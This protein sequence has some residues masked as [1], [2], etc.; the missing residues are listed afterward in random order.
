[1]T[2]NVTDFSRNL[3]GLL[4]SDEFNLVMLG[5]FGKI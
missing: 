5:Y 3:L 2:V 4:N 1:M